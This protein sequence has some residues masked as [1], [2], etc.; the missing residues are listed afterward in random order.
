[1]KRADIEENDMWNG[2]RLFWELIRREGVNTIFG[3]PGAQNLPIVDALLAGEIRFVLS[4]HE[5]GAAHMADGYARASGR[6]GVALATSGPGATNLVTGI[7]TAMRD[8]IPTVFVT[9]QVPSPLIGT[10]AFQEVDIIA[11]TRPITKGGFLVRSVRELTE[12]VRGAFTLARSG[13]QGPVLVDICRDAQ[14]ASVDPSWPDRNVVRD[15]PAA[16]AERKETE[17][18]AKLIEASSRP[19]I[20][21]GHGVLCSGASELLRRFA[22]KIDA[23]VAVTLLGLG[24]FPASHPLCLGMMGMHGAAEA[25]QAIQRADLLMALGMRFDD[26]VTGRLDAYAPNARKIHVDIDGAE[27]GRRVA[28]DAGIAGDLAAVL[29]TFIRRMPRQ[30]HDA[31][32]RSIERWRDESRSRDIIAKNGDRRLDAPHVIDALHRAT[33][34]RAVIATDVGQH[35][36]WAAQYYR[37]DSPRSFITSGGMGTMGFGLPA[38]IGAKIARP[39]AEVWA[40]VGDGGFQMTQC[41]LATLVQEHLDVKIAVINNGF[42]GMVRQWQELFYDRNYSATR[43]SS[44]DFTALAAVYGIS[45]HRV[46]RH[47]Q[48]APAIDRARSAP[49]PVL[50]DFHI[51]NESIVYPMVPAG[52]ALDEMIRRPLPAFETEMCR[53][54]ASA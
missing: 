41:E 37:V 3:Y 2:A 18:A 4:R 29:K 34:G 52:S 44:P 12:T 10:D 17:R 46:T 20:L 16:S 27:I 19:L 45:A 21:A 48:L 32:R 40:V 38:A 24:G 23:P 9:G 6:V 30:R 39:E 43:I 31:W 7:A 13:R 22:E 53:E 26:R 8:S 54:E 50:I 11:V 14:Q 5:Q 25:N 36:M 1:V 42:L 15:I 35:Q 28:V 51:E 33:K 49:G 47:E